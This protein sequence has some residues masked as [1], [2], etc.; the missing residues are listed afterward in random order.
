MCSYMTVAAKRKRETQKRP[1]E[2][3]K[4]IVDRESH[5]GEMNMLGLKESVT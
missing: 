4:Y 3:G 5:A 1:N 2:D